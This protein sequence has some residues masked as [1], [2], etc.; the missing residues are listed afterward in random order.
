VTKRYLFGGTIAVLLGQAEWRL[1]PLIHT[2]ASETSAQYIVSFQRFGG[3]G[4]E[5]PQ[6]GYTF[7]VG[8]IIRSAL[9]LEHLTQWT[10][11]RLISENMR[12]SLLVRC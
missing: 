10:L 8:L 5:P 2:I 6:I 4:N 3:L 11:T 12:V 9:H 1:H 7:S